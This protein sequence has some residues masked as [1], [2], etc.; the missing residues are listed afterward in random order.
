MPPRKPKSKK[1]PEV[2]FSFDELMS[3]LKDAVA[4]TQGEDIPV[5]ITKV[6]PEHFVT[7]IKVDR[8]FVKL[9]RAKHNMSQQELA[10]LFSVKL[11]TVKSWES[12]Q[13]DRA[14]SGAARRLFQ[15]FALQP[16]LVENF[17]VKKGA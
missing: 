17:K 9:F 11:D 4:Y 1:T 16:E 14:V 5:R 13:R 15:I 7:A 10:D 3:S 2:E 12:R 6:N 8:E